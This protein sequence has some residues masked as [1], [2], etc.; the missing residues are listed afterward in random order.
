MTGTVVTLLS[1]LFERMRDMGSSLSG[2][3]ATLPRH[4][5]VVFRYAQLH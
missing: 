5:E 3:G 1:N 4:F 2:R